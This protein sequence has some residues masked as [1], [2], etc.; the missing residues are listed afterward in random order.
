MTDSICEV[1]SKTSIKLL[2]ETPDP[3]SLEFV[4]TTGNPSNSDNGVGIDIKSNLG[5]TIS[6]TSDP[7]TLRITRTTPA[8]TRKDTRVRFASPMRSTGD[9]S[10]FGSSEEGEE[11]TQD[12]LFVFAISSFRRSLVDLSTIQT[13]RIRHCEGARGYCAHRHK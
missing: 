4:V 10:Q 2:I 6:P 9:H 12:V 1:G 13:V 5:H 11:D 8:E 7:N 3:L